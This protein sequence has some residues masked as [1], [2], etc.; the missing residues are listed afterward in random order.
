MDSLY[1]EA[2]WERVRK[3]LEGADPTIIEQARSMF[4]RAR[5]SNTQKDED[6]ALHELGWFVRSYSVGKRRFASG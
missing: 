3:L 4:E 5:D 2:A 1:D 6:S